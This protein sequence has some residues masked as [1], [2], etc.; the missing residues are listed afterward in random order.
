M[1]RFLDRN[2]MGINLTSICVP[3][4]EKKKIFAGDAC[5]FALE[6]TVAHGGEAIL[7]VTE[8]VQYKE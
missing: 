7:C 6:M 8:D 5:Q 2:H 4:F 3:L 1:W